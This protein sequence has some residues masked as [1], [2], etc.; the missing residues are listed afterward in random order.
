MSYAISTIAMLM[1]T[2]IIST[3][4]V[5]ACNCTTKSN[6]VKYA[7]ANDTTRNLQYEQYCDSIYDANPDY[8][9][10]V[11]VE[12]DEYQEYLEKHGQW[13]PE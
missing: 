13:W 6:S 9:L 4:V 5:F 8:Y 3:V 1:F 11:L 2:I 7:N 12:T 10:D